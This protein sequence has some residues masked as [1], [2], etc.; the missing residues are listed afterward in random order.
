MILL[1]DSIVVILAM[2]LFFQV[3]ECFYREF[4]GKLPGGHRYKNSEYWFQVDAFSSQSL[5][6]LHCQYCSFF[7]APFCIFSRE[8]LRQQ[9]S[10]S[11]AH[12]LPGEIIV[13]KEKHFS[14]ARDPITVLF[15][16]IANEIL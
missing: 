8:N 4:R 13:G 16:N 7:T 3:I 6:L 5:F 2:I 10:S 1:I 12:I 9:R 14:T 15:S 11:P